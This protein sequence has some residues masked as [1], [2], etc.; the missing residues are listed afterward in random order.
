[1]ETKESFKKWFNEKCS[2]S[3]LDLNLIYEHFE[4]M[5]RIKDEIGW[6]KFEVYN[7]GKF[8]EVDNSFPS[9]FEDRFEEMI[10]GNKDWTYF[11]GKKEDGKQ[12]IY[13]LKKFYLE[14]K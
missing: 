8:I 10:S 5:P 9:I 14:E 2:K 7:D 4:S 11:I 6:R 13:R 12:F 1:M 3:P